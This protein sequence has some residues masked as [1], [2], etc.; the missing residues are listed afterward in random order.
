MKL[1]L[2]NSPELIIPGGPTGNS[3]I[4]I[5][6]T[7]TTTA[8]PVSSAFIPVTDLTMSV[9]NYPVVTSLQISVAWTQG[10][11]SGT[12]TFTL[13]GSSSFTTN[14]NQSLILQNDSAQGTMFKAV[15]TLCGQTSTF[16]D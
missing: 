6:P 16:A 9:D 13:T 1:V 4:T 5:T 11:S 15:V 3:M 12:D 14:N 10:S 2:V 8:S 7:P